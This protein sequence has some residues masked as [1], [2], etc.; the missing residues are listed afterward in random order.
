[1]VALEGRRRDAGWIVLATVLAFGAQ[2]LSR[3]VMGDRGAPIVV[4]FVLGCAAYLYASRP[5][6]LPFTMLIPGLLQLAPGFLGT[7]ATFRALTMGHGASTATFFDVIL[8][9]FQLGAGIMVASLL[10]N[11]RRRRKARAQ[12]APA[13]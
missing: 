6:R 11:K 7:N 5:G 2:E 13:H 8:L 3:L 9:A 10:F 4:A 12:P 1:V